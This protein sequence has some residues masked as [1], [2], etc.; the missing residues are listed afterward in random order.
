V[1]LNV[2]ALLCEMQDRETLKF[3]F[4]VLL[5]PSRV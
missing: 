5:L 1:G 3:I 4:K 2:T